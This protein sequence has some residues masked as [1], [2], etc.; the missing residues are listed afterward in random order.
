MKKLI[1][2]L[3]LATLT[4]FAGYGQ[5]KNSGVMKATTQLK[6][7]TVSENGK[8]K[9]YSVKVMERRNY[10]MELDSKDKGM[11]NQ[12]RKPSSAYVT[13]LVAID[14]DSDPNYDDY[15]VL[16]YKGSERNNFEVVQTDN[17]FDINVDDK[18]M[19]YNVLESNYLIDKKDK[20]FFI[21]EEFESE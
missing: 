5:N 18:S 16:K 21:I 17:G 2:I 10:T 7:F 6:T 1:T 9:E 11:V 15:M 13:K 4:A 14:S 19:H 8:E 20:S 12:D 3:S